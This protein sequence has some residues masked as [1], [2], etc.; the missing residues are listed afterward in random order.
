MREA[1]GIINYLKDFKFKEAATDAAIH[2]KKF[3]KLL[4]HNFFGLLLVLSFY[5]IAGIGKN[6][7]FLSMVGAT[8]THFIFDI[9]DD[10]FQLGHVK[11]WLWPYFMILKRGV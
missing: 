7:I 3:N 9:A 4:I 2:H 11:N 1:N 8:L 5:P 10:I 6:Y